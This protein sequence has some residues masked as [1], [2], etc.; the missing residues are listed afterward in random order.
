MG[1]R[2]RRRTLGSLGSGT[3]WSYFRSKEDL[4]AAVLEDAVGAYGRALEER[5]LLSDDLREGLLT[6]SKG[7]IGKMLSDEGLALFRLITAESGHFPEIGKL[8]YAKAAGP[9]EASLAAY[10]RRHMADGA[11]LPDDP[12]RLARTLLDLCQGFQARRIWSL[13][14]LNDEEIGDEA[15]RTV[16]VFLRAFAAPAAH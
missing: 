5:L 3:L 4:F 1:A 15:S 2:A 16:D 7:L 10:L 13:E 12:A 9:L 8:F 11:L 14:V 6:F